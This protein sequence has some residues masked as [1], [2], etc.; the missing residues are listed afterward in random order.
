MHVDTLSPDEARRALA[1]PAERQAWERWYHAGVAKMRREGLAEPTIL[2]MYLSDGDWRA[3]AER[4]IHSRGELSTT[5]R[6]IKVQRRSRC[7]W[8][9]V[10]LGSRVCLLIT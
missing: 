5:E 8:H 2:P 4:M 10:V 7:D 9:I 3:V 1:D 6:G